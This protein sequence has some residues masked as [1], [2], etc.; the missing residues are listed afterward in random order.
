MNRIHLRLRDNL[1]VGNNFSFGLYLKNT[2]NLI[3][4]RVF[5]F[6]SMKSDRFNE[7]LVSLFSQAHK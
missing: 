5:T 7:A 4:R 2:Q 3:E 1:L 6:G